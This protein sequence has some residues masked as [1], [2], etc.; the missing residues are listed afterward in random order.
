MTEWNASEYVRLSELQATMAEE[1]L[2]LL[3]GSFEL[4]FSVPR[5]RVC[6]SRGAH[7]DYT[8]RTPLPPGLR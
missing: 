1:V 6:H 2:S 8:P 5:L 7:R 4:V 3:D